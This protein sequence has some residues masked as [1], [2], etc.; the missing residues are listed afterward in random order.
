MK[1]TGII[2]FACFIFFCPFLFAQA[3]DRVLP[4]PN[5]P[6]C[7]YE[8]ALLGELF[9]HMAKITDPSK[10]SAPAVEVLFNSD[11]K[12]EVCSPDDGWG[13]E[14]KT[15]RYHEE[16]V[17]GTAVFFTITNKLN[18]VTYY[19]IEGIYP[20]ELPL[21]D[22][23][24]EAEM[25]KRFVFFKFTGYAAKGRYFENYLNNL[26][27]AIDTNTKLLYSYGM[28]GDYKKII[29]NNYIPQN[30]LPYETHPNTADSKLKFYEYDPIGF[31]SL[32]K[33]Y[34]FLGVKTNVYLYDWWNESVGA[35]SSLQTVK[36]NRF[37]PRIS[38]EALEDWTIRD[39]SKP[40]RS[41]YRRSS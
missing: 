28:P 9:I 24:A 19:R 36:Q 32:E 11:F 8:K 1:L 33:G 37:M 2:F 27:W 21:Y 7:M 22:E 34:N 18:D 17:P 3:E 12:W 6:D 38:D 41:P 20:F 26:M 29:G 5:N 15:Y 13:R 23:P 14:D 31:I 10:G 39:S 30:W 4:D 40:V 25:L 35:G 16:E